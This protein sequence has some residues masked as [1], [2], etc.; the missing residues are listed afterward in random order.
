MFITGVLPLLLDDM[1]SGFNIATHVSQDADLNTMAGFTHADVE[2]AVDAFL[3]ARPALAGRPELADRER[4]LGVLERYY[5]GYRFS[6][7][8]T[9]RVFNSDMVLYFLSEASRNA[10]YPESMLDPNVRTDYSRLQRLTA[11]VGAGAEERREVLETIVSEGAIQSPVVRQFG[12]QSLSTREHV[13]S[14]LYYMGMLTLA[15]QSPHDD[16]KRLEI[17]NRVI[18][19]L[20]WEHLALLLRDQEHLVFDA[21][22]FRMALRKMAFDGDIQPFLALFHDRVVKA[23]GNKDLRRLD[24]RALKLMLLAFVAL[25]PVFYPLSEK[26]FAQ[27]YCDLF[28]G[29]ST[30]HPMARHAWLLELK[31]VPQGA[32][33]PKIEQAFA[34][35]EAQIARYASDPHLVPLLTHGRPLKAGALVFVGAKKV[36]FRPW[37]AEAATGAP[38]GG[39][40]CWRPTRRWCSSTGTSAG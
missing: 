15:E 5:D 26:E 10:G 4:L 11:M 16:Q 12:V 8:A 23:I 39:V 30:L 29:V 7:R 3:A 38:A 36:L 34:Q 9:E 1:S 19:E 37:P 13:V 35:A 21:H 40:P 33:A 31:Y 24:E 20:Q 18:R 17:P 22:D 28:L 6:P 14:L 27:G 2:Q 32:K 25:S